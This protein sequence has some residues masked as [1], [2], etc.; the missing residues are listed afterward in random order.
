MNIGEKIQVCRKKQK[1]SQEELGQ[2][3]LVSRQTISLW[4]TGQ[5][6]PTVDNLIRLKEV[7]GMTLDA[8]LCGEDPEPTPEAVEHYSFYPTSQTATELSRAFARKR[9]Y[10]NSNITVIASLLTAASFAFDGNRF[11]SGFWFGALWVFVATLIYSIVFASQNKRLSYY[12]GNGDVHF[13]YYVYDRYFTVKRFCGDKET[14]STR[15]ELVDIIATY[16]LGY[17][18]AVEC[19]NATYYLNKDE[20]IKG[21]VFTELKPINS[22]FSPDGFKRLTEKTVSIYLTVLSFAS[23]LLALVSINM[24]SQNGGSYIQNTYIFF[25]FIPIPL[26]LAV[27]GLILKIN[28]RQSLF[29]CLLG[30]VLTVMFCLYGSIGAIIS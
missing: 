9:I 28:K 4:E 21:S 13:N 10:I 14:E 12:L 3:L 17:F 22:F 24:L 16:D 1:M 27:Y 30:L 6:L 20:L 15:V 2:A 5:T 23:M 25:Y 7:F 29:F 19:K 8:I 11:I 26:A 18:L